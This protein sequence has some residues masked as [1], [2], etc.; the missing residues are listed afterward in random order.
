MNLKQ[1]ASWHAGVLAVLAILA[2]TVGILVP[3]IEYATHD[4]GGADPDPVRISAY[5]VDLTVHKDGSLDAVETIT[6]QFPEGR[7]GIFRF[8]DVADAGTD[9]RIVPKDLEITLDGSD[10][11]VDMSWERGKRYRVAKIGDPSD[12]VEAGAHTYRISWS[13]DG[14]LTSAATSAGSSGQ[15]SWAGE[16]DRSVFSWDV[17][18]GG[19]QMAIDGATAQVHLPAAPELPQCVGGTSCD[20]SVDGRTVN[21]KIGAL[22]PHTPVSMRTALDIPTPDRASVPWPV[23]L[24]A[25]LGR[26]IFVVFGL[27][28]LGVLALLLG[29]WAAGRTREKTPGFPVMYEPPA[30]LGPVQV[31]YI[32]NETVPSNAVS[33][34]LLDLAER[35]LVKLE[36]LDVSDPSTG[37]TVTGAAEREAWSGLDPVARAVGSSLGLDS[38]GGQ[39]VSAKSKDVGKTLVDLNSSVAR[40]AKGWGLESG[41]LTNTPGVP[42][43]RVL[44]GLCVVVAGVLIW[45][46][47]FGLTLLALPAA[48]FVIGAVGVAQP[49][50][51]THRTPAGREMW[52]RAGGF[53][54]LLATQSAE[55][56]FDFSARKELYT[57]FIPY[58][59]ALGCAEQWARKYEAE[60]GTP[61]PVPG[62]YPIPIGT[63]SYSSMG[64]PL[65]SFESSLSSAIGAYQA[66]QSSGGGGGGFSGGGGFGGGGGGSW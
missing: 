41:L 27:G 59:V 37:W 26:N 48:A 53:R 33:A 3:V 44:M 21:L 39:F 5:D 30:G 23:A 61:A 42:V 54:R 24:D 58:A 65:A 60:T 29:W 62:W 47:P 63:S 11:P 64:N 57:A 49:A 32:S 10:V 17:V 9:G 12:F 56:R 6:T 28:L 36:P 7:H 1:A 8:F 13:V 51:T 19:W 31:A 66:T 15:G 16:D 45:F 2:T 22:A 50:S 14:V 34:T 52:S 46:N 40:A 4:T 55:T 43:L 18:P 20:M 35:G 38:V 25:V